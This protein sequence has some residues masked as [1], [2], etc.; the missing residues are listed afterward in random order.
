VSLLEVNG[1]TTRF[2]TGQGTVHAVRGVSFRV[3][4]GEIYGIVGESGSGKSVSMLSLMGLLA[5]NGSVTAGSILFDGEEIAPTG[6]SLKEAKEYEERMRRIRGRKIGM[7][8]QDP[9]T[10]LNPVLRIGTQMTESIRL[11]LGV[12]NGEA[13]ALAAEM[14]ERVGM[15]NPK[16]RLRQYPYELSGGMRQRVVIAI[17]L[18]CSPKLIIAD[19][20]TTAL[21][22]TV[23]AQILDLIKKLARENGASVI[24]ITH[25]LGIVASICDRIAIM[26]AGKTVEEGTTDEIFY[27]TKHP[28]TKGLLSSV[29]GKNNA[30]R[31]SLVPIPGTPPDML[32]LPGGC[33]FCNRCRSA[34]NICCDYQPAVTAFSGTHSCRCWE[35]CSDRALEIIRGAPHAAAV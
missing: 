29:A 23:Q 19:E 14:L 10:C 30:E 15:S 25:D 13:K 21:D 4:A 3:E 16:Q 35:Y 9:M 8:F 20:P 5:E 31:G 24:L 11:H 28:Y 32:R 27:D 1:L 26:Y 33:A 17:A 18:S 34:R 22:V 6:S 7:I 2:S 12:S